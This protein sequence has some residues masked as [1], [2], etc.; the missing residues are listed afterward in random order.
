MAIHLR[1]CFVC[2]RIAPYDAF[3]DGTVAYLGILCCAPCLDTPRA[4]KFK[5]LVA[6]PPKGPHLTATGESNEEG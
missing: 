5:E 2:G 1:I 3:P 6:D 4:Q